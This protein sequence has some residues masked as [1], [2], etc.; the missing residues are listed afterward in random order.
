VQF[1]AVSAETPLKLRV[2]G[3]F[4]GIAETW[5]SDD[6]NAEL[7]DSFWLGEDQ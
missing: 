5:M 6:F 3:L 4:E 2:L 7:S 1:V